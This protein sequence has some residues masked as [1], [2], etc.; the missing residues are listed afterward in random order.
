MSTSGSQSPRPQQTE[1]QEEAVTF[2]GSLTAEGVPAEAPKPGPEAQTTDELQTPPKPKLC[3]TRSWLPV[4]IGKQAK[5]EMD[6]IGM[7][8]LS[9]LL[10][11]ATS[12]GTQSQTGL[13]TGLNVLV[14]FTSD[15]N[16]CLL[17]LTLL[18]SG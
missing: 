13:T 12:D 8:E 9:C 4:L 5:S 6:L 1:A 16:F 14:I 3:P 10:G 18:F 11:N 15:H 17:I 2:S 7:A